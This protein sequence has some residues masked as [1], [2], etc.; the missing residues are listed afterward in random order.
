M[1]TERE[2]ERDYV[3]NAS[4]YRERRRSYAVD[5][6]SQKGSSACARARA[7]TFA[8]PLKQREGALGDL[9]G[10]ESEPARARGGGLTTS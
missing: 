2:R 10:R 8:L 7:I 9:R 4:S 3:R 1:K 6:A 5:V